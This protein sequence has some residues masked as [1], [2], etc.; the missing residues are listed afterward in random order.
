MCVCVCVGK[1][2]DNTIYMQLGVTDQPLGAGLD[3]LITNLL[4]SIL[5]TNTFLQIWAA[6]LKPTTIFFCKI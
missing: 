1:T 6:F 2:S 3:K 5:K 4:L